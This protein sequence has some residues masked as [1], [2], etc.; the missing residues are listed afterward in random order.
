MLGKG[1]CLY[2]A[3]SAN[4]NLGCMC[5]RKIINWEGKRYQGMRKVFSCG[6]EMPTEASLEAHCDA[7]CDLPRFML[8]K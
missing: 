2:Q 6:L 3:L 8:I 5:F 1:V 4:G 7:S